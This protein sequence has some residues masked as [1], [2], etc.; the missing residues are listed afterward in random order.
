[1]V[2]MLTLSRFGQVYKTKKNR[3]DLDFSPHVVKEKANESF[4][5]TLSLSVLSMQFDAGLFPRIEDFE[6]C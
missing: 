2:S 6:A 1:M 5:A 3:S 4:F